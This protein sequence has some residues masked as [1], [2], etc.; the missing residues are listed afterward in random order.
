LSE[1]LIFAEEV[2]PSGDCQNMMKNYSSQKTFGRTSILRKPRAKGSNFLILIL[3]I[4]IIT[5]GC[6]TQH[7]YK[8]YKPVPCPC[9]KENKR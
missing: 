8:K 6:A 4:L 7:K 5:A 9:E 1:R 3:L 2:L